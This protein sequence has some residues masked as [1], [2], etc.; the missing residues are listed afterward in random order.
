M[1]Y[2]ALIIVGS[3]FHL[4][5]AYAGFVTTEQKIGGFTGPSGSN[6][7]V[8]N[9]AQA[10]QARDDL[11]IIL[12][13]QLLRALGDEQYIFADESGE[14]IVEIDDDKWHGQDVGPEDLVTI[15][16]EVDKEWNEVTIDVDR[17]HK[18]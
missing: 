13:G 1:R 12:T 14:I 16:G 2:L 3:F 11:D 15:V 9:V 7:N 5:S 8:E 4:S 18:H 10:L 6:S 17:I